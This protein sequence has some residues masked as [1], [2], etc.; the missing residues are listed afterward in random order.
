L[1]EDSKT[2]DPSGLHDGVGTKELLTKALLIRQ[3]FQQAIAWRGVQKRTK[4]P[5]ESSGSRTSE[6]NQE[7]SL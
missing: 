4:P 7:V 2:L 5:D 6:L 1:I 3:I